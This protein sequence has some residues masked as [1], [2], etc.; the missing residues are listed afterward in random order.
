MVVIKFIIRENP[1]IGMLQV[2]W[3]V[4][5]Q[6][7]FMAMINCGSGELMSMMIR[8]VFGLF[9]PWGFFAHESVVNAPLIGTTGFWN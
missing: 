7:I 8:H 3:I 9:I 5:L 6:K 2:K 4:V 1:V